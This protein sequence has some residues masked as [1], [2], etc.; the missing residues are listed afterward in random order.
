V[1]SV[2][3]AAAASFTETDS[4]RRTV[5][6][7]ERA[8]STVRALAPSLHELADDASYVSDRLNAVMRMPAESRSVI[9]IWSEPL[10]GHALLGSA[11]RI[12]DDGPIHPL[13][14]TE[15][16]ATVQRVVQRAASVAGGAAAS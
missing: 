1:N 13:F 6:R 14:P 4:A 9:S 7:R 15:L 2:L 5:V 3:E 16:V 10:S 8:Y 12:G 11:M